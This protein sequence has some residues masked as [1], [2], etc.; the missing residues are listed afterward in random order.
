[1]SVLIVELE[2][3]CKDH[4]ISIENFLKIGNNKLKSA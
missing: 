4:K 1:L 2:S 3:Y